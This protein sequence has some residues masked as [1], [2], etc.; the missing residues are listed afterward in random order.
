MHG[1]V[2]LAGCDERRAFDAISAIKPDATAFG[3]LQPGVSTVDDLR[4]QAG[5]PEMVW[6]SEDES[7][8]LE[9]PVVLTARVRTWWMSGRTVG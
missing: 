3:N 7:Q 9:Y 8:R 1:G 2:Q 6:Q 4:R 5:K